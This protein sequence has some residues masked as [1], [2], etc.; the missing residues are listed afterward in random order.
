[1]ACRFR[2][3][4][5]RA[6]GCCSAVLK[7]PG[8]FTRELDCSGL[9]SVIILLITL[10][11]RITKQNGLS[12][13][14]LESRRS[15][16]PNKNGRSAIQRAF[17][18]TDLDR[19]SQGHTCWKIYRAFSAQIVNTPERGAEAMDE[20]FDPVVRRLIDLLKKAMPDCSEDDIFWG[21][22]LPEWRPHSNPGSNRTN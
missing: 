15:G 11:Q 5:R 20:H 9:A 1:M 18:N 19:C 13:R 21:Y 14:H 2:R 22:P 12:V 10:T 6:A 4:P 3:N 16:C 8:T 7:Y 17:L